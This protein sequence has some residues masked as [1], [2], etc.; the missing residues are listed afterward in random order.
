[1]KGMLLGPPVGAWALLLVVLIFDERTSLIGDADNLPFMIV[2]STIF[3]YPAGLP[4]AVSSCLVF[5]ILSFFQ[6]PSWSL[7]MISAIVGSGVFLALTGKPAEE[8]SDYIFWSGLSCVAAS[9]N[10]LAFAQ[11]VPDTFHRA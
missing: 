3:S 7:L 1:M 10:W 8:W 6:P 2:A 9:A 11:W 4:F 5:L